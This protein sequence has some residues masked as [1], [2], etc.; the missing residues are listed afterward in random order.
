[1]KYIL[2]VVSYFL[3]TQNAH[4]WIELTGSIKGL[5]TNSESGQVIRGATIELVPFDESQDSKQVIMKAFSQDV[6]QFLFRDVPPGLYNLECKAF[7]FKTTR[8]VGIQIREDRTKLAY[9]KLVRGLSADVNEVYT[10][11][12]LE[13][14]PKSKHTNQ[15]GYRR[16]TRGRSRHYLCS[17]CR[18]HRG[19]WFT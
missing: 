8:L 15:Y 1:M 2:I 14:Q 13:A 16:I 4:A 12:S 6:G 7:G 3:L 19:S 17:F 10:Y 18:G 9:F 11:A 5:V